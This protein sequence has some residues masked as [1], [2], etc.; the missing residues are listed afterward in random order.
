MAPVCPIFLDPGMYL[1]LA[2]G[3]PKYAHLAR[4][5]HY[6]LHAM[7]GADDLEFQIAGRCRFVGDEDE[8]QRV[9]GAITFPDFDPQAA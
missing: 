2:R 3:T 5:P 4:D 7:V 6:V 1:L 9:L 8:R